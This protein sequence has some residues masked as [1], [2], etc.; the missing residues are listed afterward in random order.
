MYKV[1][2]EKT[3]TLEREIEKKEESIQHLKK[4]KKSFKKFF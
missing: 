4:Y 1:E 3:L 2:R